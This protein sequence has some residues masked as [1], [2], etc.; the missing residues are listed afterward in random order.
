[1]VL[2]QM[3]PRARTLIREVVLTAI[4]L[5][6][7]AVALNVFILPQGFVGGGFGGICSIVYYLTGLPVSVSYLAVNVVLCVIAYIILGQEFSIKM[8]FGILGLTFFLWIIPIPEQP[9]VQDKLLSAIMGGIIA[10]AS[11]GTY[12][13]QGSSTGGSDILVMIISKYK[14][15]SWGKVYL[16]FDACVITSSIL[17]PGRTLETVAYGFVYLGVHAQVIDLVHSGIRQSVQ[18]FIFTSKYQEI[19]D[20]I[21][22]KHRRGVTLF[23]SIG[24]YTKQ[25]TKTIFLVARKRETQEIFKT[26]KAIDEHAFIAV[27]NAMSVFGAGFDVIKAGFKKV[28]IE[29]AE[30]ESPAQVVKLLDAEGREVACTGAVSLEGGEAEGCKCEVVG[31]TVEDLKLPP[32]MTFAEAFVDNPEDLARVLHQKAVEQAQ[33]ETERNS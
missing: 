2:A 11:T 26:V 29:C 17:L 28:K 5:S 18:M 6:T 33:S 22:S 10:G 12:L 20:R 4:A 16:A 8:V 13:L 21:I 14:N 1:M 24:W 32:S 27:S 31:E 23:E 7:Y 19:A 30:G 15:I 9:V 3:N 25:H